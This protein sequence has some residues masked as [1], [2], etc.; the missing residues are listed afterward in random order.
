MLE[1]FGQNLGHGIGLEFRESIL[2]INEKNSHTIE[3][4]MVFSVGV[5]FTGM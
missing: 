1:F 4:N 2:L 3:K 5:N